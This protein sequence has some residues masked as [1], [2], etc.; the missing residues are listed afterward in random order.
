[1]K[2]LIID[3]ETGGL[4][5]TENPLLSLGAKVYGRDLTF[6]GECSPRAGTKCTDIALKI[7]GLD[8]NK[9]GLM[10][11][12]ELLEYWKNWLEINGPFDYMAGC[13]VGFDSMF[14]RVA[15]L[16]Y[17]FGD[18]YYRKIEIQTVALMCHLQGLIKLPI[19][20][21]APSLS[22]DSMLQTFGIHRENKIHNALEDC[23]LT[24]KVLEKLFM[25]SNIKL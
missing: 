1:M 23:M 2:I 21:N 22:L 4:D 16:K 8:P 3:C 17:G 11:E 6:Y 13:N 15:N 20:R 10:T 5:P 9:V 18:Y 24:E 25:C 14:L 7:N 12:K 19:K